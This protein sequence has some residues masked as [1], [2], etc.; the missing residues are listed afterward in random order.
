[1]SSGVGAGV[2]TGCVSIYFGVHLGT[3]ITN[4]NYQPLDDYYTKSFAPP[5][6]SL[7]EHT[8]TGIHMTC[9][10]AFVSGRCAFHQVC[11]W[12]RYV[13]TIFIMLASNSFGLVLPDVS[14]LAS[15]FSHGVLPLALANNV[16]MGFSGCS[17]IVLDAEKQS[18]GKLLNSS[19]H[20]YE[21][22]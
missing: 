3:K 2:G 1:M 9:W 15:P 18:K 12:K 21:P 13:S 10:Y 22:S 5:A 19:A 4:D 16:E 11:K 7:Q 8:Y 14:L 20:P 6:A 17:V